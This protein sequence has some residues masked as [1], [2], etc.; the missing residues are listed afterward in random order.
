MAEA[1]RLDAKIVLDAKDFLNTINESEKK[2]EGFASKLGGGLATAAKVGGAAIAAAGTAVAGFAASSIKTGMDFDSSVSQLSATMASAAQDT[3][4][5]NGQQMTAIEALKAKSKELGATTMFTSQQ[6]ADGFNVL[7]M[8]G[9]DANESLETLPDVMHL[10]AAGG[11]DIAQ[12]ADYATGIMAGFGESAG[13]AGKVSD[14]LAT[15]ASQAKGDV[16][17]FGEA[18]STVAGMASTT[19]QTMDTAA[20]ALEILG[21]HNLSAAEAGNA[22][23]R[24]LKNLYQPTSTGAKGLEALGVSA[25]DAMG[26][27]RPLNDVL[28]DLNKATAGMDEQAK[29]QALSQIFDAATLKSVPFLINDV[30]TSWDGLAQGLEESEGAAA[31]ME[32]TMTDNLAGSLTLFSSALDGVKQTVSDGLSPTFKE[33]VDLASQG[34]SDINVA[35]QEGGFT[36]AIDAVGE[37]MSQALNKV[38]EVIPKFMDAG[39]QLL[40]ALVQG[41][42]DNLPALMEAAV[43][44][45][46]TLVSGI[47]EA[48]PDLIPAMVQAVITMVEGL[49]QNMPMLIEAAV[50]LIT[51]L[52]QGLVQ[53]LPLLLEQ[54]PV[55]IGELVAQLIANMPLLIECALQL[56][57]ALAQGLILYIPNLIAA[58]PQIIMAIVDTFKN[59]DWKTMAKH[60]I[61]GLKQ[62]L[63]AG[64]KNVVDSVKNLATKMLDKFKS[65]FGIHSPSTVMQQAGKDIGTGLQNGMIDIPAKASQLFSN[66][67]TGVTNLLSKLRGDSGNQSAQ[68]TRQMVTQMQSMATQSVAKMQAMA[69]Q[70]GNHMRNMATNLANSARQMMTNVVNQMQAMATQGQQKMQ[71]MATNI[72][73]TASQIPNQLK[74]AIQGAVNNVSSWGTQLVNTA[75]NGVQNMVKSAV[76]AAGGLAGQFRSIGANLVAG[77]RSGIGGAISGLYN[78]IYN[79]MKG[80]VKRAKHALGIHSPSKEFAEIGKFS[81]AGLGE[82]WDKNIK[83]VRQQIVED[84]DFSDV[85]AEVGEITPNGISNQNSQLLAVLAQYLPQILDKVGNDIYLDRTK[86]GAIMDN[87]LGRRRGMARRANA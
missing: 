56:I 73:N 42:I 67:K 21:N 77:L 80:L 5:Y 32:K 38:I 58:I 40:L 16:S 76:S 15:M 43:Q 52:A 8:A 84:M 60:V 82:G 27:A 7:A 66:M 86:V 31:E 36:G 62:G 46:V 33:F 70:V 49:I 29:N 13:D 6:A 39:L 20:V 3:I 12:A 54:A 61:D 26:N 47:G 50:Q 87:E 23:S 10:A 69:S 45:V 2:S 9:M 14:Y 25:Y 72:R 34:L 22:L 11:L 85:N 63:S 81:V 19:G 53:A 48:L 51:G 55:L 57:M 4:T 28:L 78:S 75:R 24:T 68:M 74:S 37:F 30:T 65:I 83:D 79:N 17:Q 41:I 59:Y 18:L 35:F 71:S 64:V 1:F 44:V